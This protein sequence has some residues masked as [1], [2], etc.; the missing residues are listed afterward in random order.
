MIISPWY[1]PHVGGVVMTIIK[2]V[3]GLRAAGAEVSI[4]LNGDSAKV[5]PEGKD[6]QTAIFSYRMRSPQADHRRIR[7]FVAWFI[8]FLPT[9]FNLRRFV[10]EQKIDIIN[11]H[12][13]GAEYVYF[14]LLK[15]LLPVKVV[16]SIHGSDMRKE[17]HTHR[18]NRTLTRFLLRRADVLVACSED[19]RLYVLDIIGGKP[20][21]RSQVVYGGVEADWLKVSDPDP[22]DSRQ[23]YLLAVG[24][25]FPVKGFDILIRAFGQ[26][27]D[28]D[29]NLRLRIVGD[30]PSRDELE[31]LTKEL[32]LTEQVKFDGNLSH[33][34]LRPVYRGATLCLIPSRNEALSLVALEA[35]AIGLAVVASEIGGLPEII[36]HGVNGLLC[37]V[38]DVSALSQAMKELINDPSRCHEMGRIGRQLVHDKFTWDINN[39]KYIEIFSSLV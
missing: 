10:R 35:Q 36:E 13:P 23:P 26:L 9:L 31:Q 27:V 24:T 29:E 20:Q 2:L 32:G 4:L 12:Y 11:I 7:S 17:F 14:A 16:V 37:P 18:F 8:F 15:L 39:Q 19:L 33:E 30:G 21:G 22:S 6:G 25:L 38:E 3:N 28:R 5:Q 34:A 1:K